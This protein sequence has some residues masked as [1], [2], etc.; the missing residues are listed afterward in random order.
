M[1]A[2][3]DNYEVEEASLNDIRQALRP[4]FSVREALALRSPQGLCKDASG[5]T[6]LPGLPGINNLGCTDY[7]SSVLHLLARVGPMRTHFL[8]QPHAQAGNH[9]PVVREFGAL[10]RRLWAPSALRATVTPHAFV[11]AVSEASNKRFSVGVRSDAVSFLTWLLHRLH[12]D[13]LGAYPAHEAGRRAASRAEAGL[14]RRLAAAPSA[15]KASAPPRP[16][17]GGS[18]GRWRVAG[19]S[20]PGRSVVSEC[21]QGEVQV[22]TLRGAIVSRAAAD[23]AAGGGEG[24]ADAA[25]DAALWE[26]AG[27]GQATVETR[28]V[29]TQ[30]LSLDLP[31]PPLFRS[32][33]GGLDIPQVALSRC[34]DKF[35]G[36]VSTAEIVGGE[37]VRRRYSLVRAPLFLLLHAR[38]FVSNGFFL[39][40][41]PTI[42]TFPLKG[43]SAEAAMHPLA[44]SALFEGTLPAPSAAAS[45]A[46]SASANAVPPSAA[47]SSSS[48]SSLS[49]TSSSHSK[50]VFTLPPTPSDAASLPWPAL[51]RLCARAGLAEEAAAATSIQERCGIARR[52]WA[53]LCSHRYDLLGTV[54]HGGGSASAATSSAEDAHDAEVKV[55]ASRARR[56]A[57]A[58]AEAERSGRIGQGSVATLARGADAAGLEDAASTGSYRCAVLSEAAGAWFEADDN[59]VRKV[60]AQ[61]IAVSEAYLLLYTKSE[62]L[63]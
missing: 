7:I 23:A 34:L 36:V 4:T 22:Q 11:S 45:P 37:P 32:A 29:T 25:A 48:S 62:A 38:R 19:G 43:L 58:S 59:D 26:A 53:L 17:P 9:S 16:A 42:V 30:M 35:G 12:V 20:G 51:R 40:K 47:G 13:L 60:L 21:F 49:A 3:A 18:S 46:A 57:A 28:V 8:L 39:E 44:D 41:N 55:G 27:R 2:R 63:V 15:A 24:Q 31:P 50:A 54:V 6:Y 56:R 10:M 1:L 5:T 52:A 33:E 61:S 14:A